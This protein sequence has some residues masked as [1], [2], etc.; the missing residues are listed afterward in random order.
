MIG[1]EDL[2]LFKNSKQREEV[3][4]QNRSQQLRVEN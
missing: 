2:L 1:K 3:E 4:K